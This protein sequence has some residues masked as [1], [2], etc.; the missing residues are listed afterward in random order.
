MREEDGVDCLLAGLSRAG[1]VA[2]RV[3]AGLSRAGLGFTGRVAGR[4][5]FGVGLPGRV[6]AGRSRP[7]F[8]VTGRVVVGLSMD[9]VIG[10]PVP[11]RPV[12]GLS[13]PGREE[14]F[15]APGLVTGCV[16]PGF[17]PGL[18]VDGRLVPGL[19]TTGRPVLS[20]EGSLSF[21]EGAVGF[22]LTKTAEPCLA[23]DGLEYVFL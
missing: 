22:L 2:G 17:V 15:P 23:D 12:P 19:L 3:C 21:A 9:V 7:G 18:P 16:T 8:G 5:G 1:R 11:G 4:C 10:L 20:K 6:V 14:P 13:A